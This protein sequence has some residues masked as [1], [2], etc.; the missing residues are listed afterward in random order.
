MKKNSLTIAISICLGALIIALAI[1]YV[2]SDGDDR[3][4]ITL[5]G[6][7]DVRQ[8]DI[9][10]RVS[11]QV[12]QLLFEEGDRVRPGDLMCTLDSTPYDSQLQEAV[13]NVGAIW[14]SLDNAQTLLN[15]R[16]ELIDI[17]AVSQ[18]DLDNATSSRDQLR[19]NLAQAEAAVVVAK[20][21]IEYT[22]A[23]A[24]TE[25]IILT[26]IREPGTVVNPA[27]PVYTLSI[28]DPVWIRA[29]VD[30]PYLGDVYYG[31]SAEVF[32]DN[33]RKYNGT[34]GFISPVAEFTP[35]TVQTLELRTDLVYRLRVYV[36]N[37]D[38]GLVQGMPVTV[39]L[40]LKR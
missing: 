34:V 30:E 22:K 24:P 8:V 29:F 20:D 37:P 39:K 19:A 18:E 4:E 11:G 21:N 9:G 16:L 2:R 12:S 26:R 27:D 5:F 1:L 17:G 35:K 15:R 23:Y 25:G 31:M 7:V 36:E 3:N 6:N 28:S 13:A 32:T 10:F 38:R 14:A 33:G 40:K